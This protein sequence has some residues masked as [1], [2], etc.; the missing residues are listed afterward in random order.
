MKK[1]F[2]P[3]A[4]L[5]GLLTALMLGGTSMAQAHPAGAPHP[6]FNCNNVGVNL[7]TCSKVIATVPVV[8]PIADNDTRVLTDNELTGVENS[9]NNA[10]IDVLNIDTSLKNVTVAVLNVYN[11]FNPTV[12]VT[13]IQICLA[14]TCKS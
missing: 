6:G 7:V 4:L 12:T 14:A 5:F 1:R 10:N 3:L 9:L 2:A 13:G 11:S 8:I